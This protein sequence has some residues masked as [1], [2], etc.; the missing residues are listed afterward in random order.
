MAE[1][2]LLARPF[3]EVLGV[4]E[5]CSAFGFAGSFSNKDRDLASSVEMMLFFFFS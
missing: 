2:V 3:R 5:D 4:F 1:E